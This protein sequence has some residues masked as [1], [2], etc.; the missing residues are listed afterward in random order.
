MSRPLRGFS[1]N[2]VLSMWDDIEVDGGEFDT[3]SSFSEGSDDE[4]N[5]PPTSSA[6]ASASE[7]KGDHQP[8]QPLKRAR[9]ATLSP[10]EWKT[11]KDVDMAPPALR[12]RPLRT[13]GVQ[14]DTT[15]RHTPANLF[16]LFFS[17]AVVRELCNYTNTYAAVNAA[18]KSYAWVDVDVQEFYLF[19]GLLQ[20]TAIM[21]L[22]SVEDY[23]SRN[24]VLGVTFAA[25]VMT[26]ARFQ[27]L[28][29][30]IH[31]SD[32]EGD[33]QNDLQKGTLDHN[34]LFRV[35]PL[36]DHMRVACKSSYHPR[37]ELAVDERMVATKAKTGFTQ[38]IKNKPTRWGIK[39]FVMADSSNGYTVDFSV[40]VGKTFDS[41]EKGLSYDA[42]M[43]LVQPAFLGTG[44][45]VYVDNFY[46]SPTLF[47]DLSNLKMGACGTYRKGRK[48]CPPSQGVMTRK[49]PRGT[50]RWL[51]QD[52][53]VFVKWMDTR[54]VSVCSTIHAAHAGDTVR[55][56]VK[57]RD[58]RYSTMEIPCPIPVVQYNK[59]MGGVDRSDQ[60]IQYYSA[61][62][63]VSRS[64]R[65]LFLHF[66]DIASTNAYILHL[67]LAQASQQKPLSHKAFLL[68]LAG[69][70]C[71]VEPSGVPV[72]RQTTHLPVGCAEEVGNRSNKA[73][74]G[75]R[76]CQHC[77]A[78]GI[79]NCTPWK[80]Q[81]CDV[82][83]CL[84]LDRNCF[85]EWHA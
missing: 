75:R 32:L 49:T 82:P 77:S 36:L 53:M 4:E 7:P 58:G 79:R 74:A 78:K 56:K 29:W 39:L 10:V 17:P 26:R 20:H 30:N 54:E 16:R 73:T 42:V 35:Q 80:C 48:G 65:T 11:E 66:F 46:T 15:V 13:P 63:R 72:H 45:H 38:Y 31:L 37:R 44:Y 59:Y 12:F 60:L 23:W 33:Q 84:Q 68:Q 55:R 69:E 76:R 19:L 25:S 71:E 51:R 27:S 34:R 70:L 28:L 64:Y 3:E 52:P 21:K 14:V 62:R 47:T 50:M 2:E 5:I 43:D 8:H 57:S 1:V 6:A 18:G 83:L 40:Y 85:A 61:H 9:R 24:P 67:E 22:P 81:A 41:S